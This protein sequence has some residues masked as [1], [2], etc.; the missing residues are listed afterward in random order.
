M[1][2]LELSKKKSIHDP[3]IRQLVIGRLDICK[4]IPDIGQITG[5]KSFPRESRGITAH[6]NL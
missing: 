2:M 4:S 1:C 3:C 6:V 5:S